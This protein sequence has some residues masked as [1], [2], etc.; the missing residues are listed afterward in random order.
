MIPSFRPIKM[1]HV[2]NIG[3]FAQAERKIAETAAASCLRTM[4][5]IWVA[6]N[7]AKEQKK[8]PTDAL[9][10]GAHKSA[11]FFCGMKNNETNILI[12]FQKKRREAAILLFPLFLDVLLPNNEKN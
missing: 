9:F 1:L 3:L 8:L 4:F 5:W 10:F 11:F 12:G 2:N 7:H 6:M